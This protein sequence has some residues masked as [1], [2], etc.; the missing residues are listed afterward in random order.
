M[1]TNSQIIEWINAN[2][3][4][5]QS[6]G[7]IISILL[8][9][10][11]IVFNTFQS[12]ILSRQLKISEDQAKELLKQ[13]KV[14]TSSLLANRLDEMNELHLQYPEIEEEMN[15][16]YVHSTEGKAVSLLS[17]RRWNLYDLIYFHYSEKLFPK[18][19]FLIWKA[20]I[21]L[22]FVKK[23]YSRGHW[24]ANRIYYGHGVRKVID[25]I[26]VEAMTEIEEKHKE[27]PTEPIVKTNESQPEK[28]DTLEQ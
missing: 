12:R 27:E 28:K 10:V 21:K 8:G 24:K 5:I 3:D 22:T 2:K 7:V 17:H 23:K 26:L 16:D 18:E 4:L 13:A 6:Y 20:I 11:A 14:N 25:E 9:F 19:E 15:T 1:D